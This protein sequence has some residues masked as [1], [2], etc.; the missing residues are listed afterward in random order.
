MIGDKHIAVNN[1]TPES[2]D[3]HKY[4]REMVD[5]GCEAV[6]M[7]ASSQGFKASSYGGH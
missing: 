5:A 1:T 4:F 6:V 7:E 3:I 2:Y